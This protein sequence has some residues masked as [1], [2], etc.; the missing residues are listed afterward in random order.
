MSS[1]VPFPSQHVDALTVPHQRRAWT[2]ASYRESTSWLFRL[3]NKDELFRKIRLPNKEEL[4]KKIKKHDKY[5]QYCCYFMQRT[6]RKAFDILSNT[7]SRH[8]QT[9]VVLKH[10]DK[11]RFGGEQ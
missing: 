6:V 5:Y 3:P 9:C 7:V 11:K 10:S 1:G 2:A 4:F 8:H